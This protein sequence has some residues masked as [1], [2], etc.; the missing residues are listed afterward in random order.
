MTESARPSAG[1]ILARLDHLTDRIDKLTAAVNLDH[2]ALTSLTSFLKGQDL[3]GRVDELEARVV[4]LETGIT[5]GEGRSAAQSRLAASA[6][7]WLAALAAG[8]M[9]VMSWLGLGRH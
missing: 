3:R 8:T 6:A 5:H 2:D 7:S 4:S 9:A 1:V